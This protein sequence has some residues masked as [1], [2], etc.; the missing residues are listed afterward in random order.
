MEPG[1]KPTTLSLADQDTLR[2]CESAIEQGLDSAAQVAAALARIR[3][4]KL[5]R[6]GYGTW[7]EYLE[8][9]WDRT[10]QWAA[11]ILKGVETRKAITDGGQTPGKSSSAVDS[12]QPEVKTRPIPERHTRPLNEL[13]EEKRAEAWERVVETAPKDPKSGKRKITGEH[14]AEVVKEI[15]GDPPAEIA[16][17]TGTMVPAR[18]REVFGIV[19]AQFQKLIREVDRFKAEAIRLA[20]SPHG[21]H[22]TATQVQKDAENLRTALKFASPYAVCSR[23]RGKGCKPCK[24]QGWM[25]LDHH[26]AAERER[27]RKK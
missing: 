4:G 6:G 1:M 18:L 2:A 22:L 20:E 24:D 7:D 27:G 23:C 10:R 16:D 5:Y 26:R 13:P 14:V 15:R 3:D 19:R 12:F 11:L 8:K 17:A 25:T 9:R 21:L